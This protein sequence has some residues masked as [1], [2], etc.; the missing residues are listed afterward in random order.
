MKSTTTT[1]P[2]NN[3]MADQK[4]KDTV[5]SS[6]QK[7]MADQHIME[8]RLMKKTS[9]SSVPPG[10]TEE[11]NPLQQQ[12]Q[13]RSAYHV[14]FAVWLSMIVSV[15][16][17][18]TFGVFLPSFQAEWPGASKADLGLCGSFFLGAFLGGGLVSG[19]TIPRFGHQRCAFFGALGIAA[20][21]ACC[22]LAM[23]PWQLYLPL[24]VLGLSSNHLWAG[25][26]ALIPAHFRS[27][28]PG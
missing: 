25:G 1:T 28:S 20:A 17:V 6:I 12:Q 5:A 10:T 27:P 7:N 24:A 18:Y 2:S 9:S 14:V 8:H 4:L 15:S 23:A 13:Q 19:R 16:N 22:S 3:N 26:M 11:N 21:W